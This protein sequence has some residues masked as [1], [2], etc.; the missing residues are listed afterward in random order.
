[1]VQGGRGMPRLDN[2]LFTWL[3][4]GGKCDPYLKLSMGGETVQTQ[5]CKRTLTPVWNETLSL[6]LPERSAGS[7]VELVV[8]AYDHDLVRLG[9]GG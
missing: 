8:E 6:K 2:G 1:V 3:R 5:V 9:G 4:G 7:D